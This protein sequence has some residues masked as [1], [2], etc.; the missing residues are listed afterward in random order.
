MSAAT[1]PKKM[2]LPLPTNTLVG[3]CSH[4]GPDCNGPLQT[5]HLIY[6]KDERK[7]FLCEFHN[8]TVQQIRRLFALRKR[9]LRLKGVLNEPQRIRCYEEMRK[10]RFA[11]GFPQ[12][13]H[14]K[15]EAIADSLQLA[16]QADWYE[17][18][19][20][21]DTPKAGGP[22]KIRLEAVAIGSPVKD[23]EWR[24]TI[25]NPE[26]MRKQDAGDSG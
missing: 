3:K 21:Q 9:E 16:K 22:I 15:C 1:R 26:M 25:R 6:G 11:R 18:L 14:R 19:S 24:I 20:S 10:R 5:E 23:W 8:Q 7:T 17:Q 2:H 13:M 12:A 4:A